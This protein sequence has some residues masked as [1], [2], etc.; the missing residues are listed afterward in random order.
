MK[1]R[2]DKSRVWN[3]VQDLVT[4]TNQGYEKQK[5][6]GYCSGLRSLNGNDDLMLLKSLN[7]NK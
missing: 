2:T 5:G 6:R 1:K 4:C 7:W 3:I